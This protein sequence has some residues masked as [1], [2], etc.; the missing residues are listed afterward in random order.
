MFKEE[1]LK[2]EPDI[3]VCDFFTRVGVHIADDLKIPCVVNVPGLISFRDNCG[4]SGIFYYKNARNCCGSV[5]ISEKSKSFF[6]R[7][8]LTYVFGKR[9]VDY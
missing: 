7:S 2:I 4:V 9:R 5:C 3:I 6:T 1:I 8:L